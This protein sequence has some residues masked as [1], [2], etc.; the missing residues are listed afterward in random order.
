MGGLPHSRDRASRLKPPTALR[1][2][3]RP[4]DG[5]SVLFRSCSVERNGVAPASTLRVVAVRCHSP[6][7]PGGRWRSRVHIPAPRRRTCS[8][9]ATCRELASRSREAAVSAVWL[10]LRSEVRR[11]W[12]AWIGL[13]VLV[14]FAGG[15]A[16]ALAQAARRS[17][18]AYVRFSDRESAADVV[19]TGANSF[20]LVGSVDLAAVARSGY[21][22]QRAPAFVGLPFSGQTDTGRALNAVDLFPVAAGDNQLGT[23]VERWKMLE[24]RRARPSR[25]REA[26][27][28]FVLAERLGLHVGSTLELRFYRADRF[29]AVAVKLLAS[30]APRINGPRPREPGHSRL[31][32]WSPREVHRRRDRGVPARVP[33]VAH[34]SRARTAPHTRVRAPLREHDRRQS[35]LLLPAPARARSQVVRARGRAHGGGEPGVVRQH[36]T[37]RARRCSDRSAPKRWRWRSS[38]DSSGSPVRSRSR[39]H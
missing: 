37:T 34:R 8:T 33:T 28:S 24:G 4:P 13:A 20:G 21:I 26:T 19:M 32:G 16:M 39:R 36:A 31:R 27:A 12:R 14:G 7:V 30:L 17:Q 15:A 18:H 10:R 5:V 2:E 1:S 22:A 23:T 6:V 3:Q 38:P 11:R 9:F 29:A 25:R 35:P